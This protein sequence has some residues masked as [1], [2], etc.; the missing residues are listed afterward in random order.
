MSNYLL[1]ILTVH[2]AFLIS[3]KCNEFPIYR[4]DPNGKILTM[5]TQV[6]D[7]KGEYNV[8]FFKRSDDNLSFFRI[9]DALQV[10]L[11]SPIMCVSKDATAVALISAFHDEGKPEEEILIV[12]KITREKIAKIAGFR[13]KDLEKYSDNTGFRRV[14]EM[15]EYRLWCNG[16]IKFDSVNGVVTLNEHAGDGFQYVKGAKWPVINIPLSEASQK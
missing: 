14:P 7:K 9:G 8:S 5:M 2:L 3:G 10:I 11:N 6:A 12:Y 16:P 15:S 13:Y 1:T 4:G